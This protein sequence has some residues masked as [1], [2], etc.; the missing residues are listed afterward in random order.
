MEHDQGPPGI[1]LVDGVGQ[2]VARDVARLTEIRGQVLGGDAGPLA[3]G[4]AQGAEQ[5]LDAAEVLADVGGQQVGGRRLELHRRP[6][7]V[8]VQ[9]RLALPRLARGHVD[10]PPG[11]VHR[12]DQRCGDRPTAAHQDQHGRR[13]RALDDLDQPGHVGREQPPRLAHHHDAPVH[14]EGRG[15]A[16]VDDGPDAQLLARA[17]T[18]LLDDEGVVEI[19]HHLGQQGTHLLGDHGGV[20]TLD[21]IRRCD[22]LAHSASLIGGEDVA[23]AH[24][25][26]DVVHPHDAA[27]PGDAE[28]R[29]A[30]GSLA[31]LGELQVEHLAEEGLV[32]R[33]EQQRVAE[34]G[35]GRR[36]AQQGQR[37]LGRLA[38]VEAGVE[39]DAV[40]RDARGPGAGGP[41][42]EEAGH[43][44]RRRRRSAGR[45]RRTR[46]ARRMWVMTTA[47]P[48]SAAAAA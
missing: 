6:A 7:Q 23:H 43:V 4:G 22:R 26:P 31:T 35:Q 38:E 30:D 10:D 40:G 44:A 36:G 5:A 12:L 19:A 47:A 16:G 34:R 48:C 37:L 21:E 11:R 42:G 1:A 9:P 27:A 14:Q 33:G 41:L 2:L 45:G 3:V 32:R 46:G 28:C 39:H 18:D 29:R 25:A 8:V 15:E 13:E 20:V 24:G 17:A